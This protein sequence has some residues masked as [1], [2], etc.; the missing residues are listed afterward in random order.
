MPTLTTQSIGAASGQIFTPA[1]A[2][3][4]RMSEAA[5]AAGVNQAQNLDRARRSAITAQEDRERSVQLEKRAE[6]TFSGQ[7]GREEKEGEGQREPDTDI[8]SPQTSSGRLNRTA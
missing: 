7:D 5:Q 4:Q 1:G 8:K 2:A 3:N 6:G